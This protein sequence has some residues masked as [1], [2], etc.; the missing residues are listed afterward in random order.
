LRL[1]WLVSSGLLR[2]ISYFVVKQFENS[3]HGTV[4]ASSCLSDKV[5]PS[6]PWCT[7]RVMLINLILNVFTLQFHKIHINFF[8]IN[9]SK[10]MRLLHLQSEKIN[11]KI[12]PFLKFSSYS[13]RNIAQICCWTQL[14]FNTYGAIKKRW[15]FCGENC[16]E[17]RCMLYMCAVGFHYIDYLNEITLCVLY[18]G[19]LANWYP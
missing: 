4:R 19:I 16:D 1:S 6:E 2:Q 7:A 12:I 15:D 3:F 10:K 17:I 9:S 18:Y 8:K 13:H 5:V 11:L 14:I